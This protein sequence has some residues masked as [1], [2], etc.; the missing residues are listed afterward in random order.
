MFLTEDFLRGT[1]N[2]LEE[3]VITTDKNGIIYGMNPSAEKLTGWSQGDVIDQPL[4]KIYHV[5]NEETGMP[6][7]NIVSRILREGK[8]IEFENNTILKK[9]NAEQIIIS[10]NGSPIRNKQGEIIGSVLVFRDITD[11][12]LLAKEKRELTNRLL[13]ATKING[14][15]IWEWDVTTNKLNWDDGMR[16]LFNVSTEQTESI[17]NIWM[18]SV[19][20]DDRIRVFN[21]LELAFVSKKEYSSEYR[22]ILD[23]G[24]LH[25]LK[26]SGTI[27]YNELNEVVRMIGVNWDITESKLA[28]QHRE[29]VTSDLIQRNKNMEQFSFIVS[30]NLR[31]PLANIMGFAELLKSN[32]LSQEELL[33]AMKNMASAAYKLDDVVKDL[34]EILQIK[35]QFL[36][37]KEWVNFQE[38]VD[39]IKVSIENIIKYQNVNIITE[40]NE[41][42][43]MES[44]KSYM[45]SIFYNLIYN[46]IKYKKPGKQIKIVIKSVKTKDG[47]KLIFRDNGMGIDLDKY[48]DNIFVL[49][50]RFHLNTEGK[51]M[52]LFM[53][54]TQVETLG[55]DISINSKVEVGTE[56]T[57]TF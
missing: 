1:L 14:M 33:D 28:E 20:P 49:Y 10:N 48:R 54:K 24:T 50:K 31:G 7:E 11:K 46:S 41:L 51:G 12:Y 40:F 2:S 29:R 56:F 52:G 37:H 26:A 47:I 35:T 18:R 4:E 16:R 22:I 23:D 27:E 55:G 3:G 5:V 19:H 34:N 42:D 53:V 57:L 43:G 9:K 21:E 32:T 39:A 6:F 38:I 36:E 44:V 8:T 25:Y 30:H 13:L 15:G 45:H 17:E